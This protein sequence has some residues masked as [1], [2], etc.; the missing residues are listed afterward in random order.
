ML[1]LWE[2]TGKNVH[3]VSGITHLIFIFYHFAFLFAKNEL[4]S[5][6]NTSLISYRQ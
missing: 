2:Y 3:A 1:F 5:Q 6:P 4:F